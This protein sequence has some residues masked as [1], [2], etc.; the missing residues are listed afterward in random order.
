[1]GFRSLRNHPGQ[2]AAVSDR[3]DSLS[4]TLSFAAFLT[5]T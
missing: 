5:F 1:M 2:V 3:T 4:A